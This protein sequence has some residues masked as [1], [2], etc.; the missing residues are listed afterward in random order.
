MRFRPPTLP[1]SHPDS[2]GGPELLGTVFRALGWSRLVLL[3]HLLVVNAMRVSQAAH[4][5]LLVVASLVVMVW[6]LTAFYLGRRH[7]SRTTIDLS[8]DLVL[9]VGL[10]AS[11]RY[12]L[13]AELLQDGY[14]GVTC[15]WMLAA[16]TGLAIYRGIGWGLLAGLAIGLLQFIQAPSLAPRAWSDLLLMTMIP[17]FG[18]L[19]VAKLGNTMAERDRSFATAAA[20]EERE[21]LHRI[22]HDGVLQ[23]LAMVAREGSELGPRGQMLASLAR[24]HEDQLRVTLQD[25]KVDVVHGGFLDADRTDITT[26]LERHQGRAVTV[27]TMADEVEMA[28][29][30]AA[31]LDRVVTEALANVSRHA[32]P[33]AQAWVLLE[34]EGND[35][36]ITIRDDG[37]GMTAQELD[38]AAAAGR[39]GVRESIIGRLVDLHGSHRLHSAPGEG[40]EWEFRIPLQ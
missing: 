40:T 22:L 26:M 27:S 18:G 36:V 6:S 21:R 11:S 1:L 28:S 23:V 38:E 7:G 12:V 29:A 19:L 31:E 17:C 8:I 13:G 4:P 37:R 24:R 32:G 34:Q 35:V 15:F 30:R 9:T 39:L 5:V 16:P 10:V 14:F 2:A 3:A 25:R 33:D 20:L